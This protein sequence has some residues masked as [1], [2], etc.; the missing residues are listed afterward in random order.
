MI[1]FANLFGNLGRNIDADLLRNF[2]AFFNRNL[3]RH[4]PW[5]LLAN[6]AGHIN[7]NLFRNLLV[8]VHAVDL[9][10]RGALGH[11]G[12]VGSFDRNLDTVGDRDVGALWAVAV[13]VTLVVSMSV[14]RADLFLNASALLLVGGG[15]SCD[16]NFGADILVDSDALLVRYVLV[17]GLAL[18]VVDRLA[19]L[20]VG[21]L[22][23]L[24]VDGL[25][26]G[27]ADGGV[28]GVTNGRHRE[29]GQ[30]Q[31]LEDKVLS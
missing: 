19:S 30:D 28:A 9:G 23:L 15:V 17:G 8:G 6:L 13:G 7:A 24:V 4:L 5:N 21:R 26:D 22:A 25:V 14:S 11:I 16:G 2:L 18:L 1:F 3:N 29:Q 31:N 27:L 20:L 12:G 10:N